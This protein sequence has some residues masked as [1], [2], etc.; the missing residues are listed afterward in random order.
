M[1][2]HIELKRKAADNRRLAQWRV[3]WFIEHS[4]PHHLLWCIENFSLQIP[5]LR[6]APN[7]YMLCYLKIALKNKILKTKN[8]LN[9]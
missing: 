6:Q 9:K 7:R 8:K 2:E 5:P 4:T 1:N 3:T